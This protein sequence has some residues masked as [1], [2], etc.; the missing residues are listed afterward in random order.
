MIKK[1]YDIV[2]VGAGLSGAVLAE[3]FAKQQK[4]KVLLIEK[5]DHIGGNCFD[6]VDKNGI[7]INKYGAHLFHTN[8]EDVWEYVN[9]FCPWERWDHRVLGLLGN[10]LIN[11]PINI[12]TVNS[13]FQ[14][15]LKNGDDMDEWLSINQVNHNPIRDSKEMA[16]SRIGIDLY[17]KVIKHYSHKQWGKYPEELD[18]SV[19]ARIPVRNSFDDRYFTDKYQVLPERGYTFF[20]QNLL[21]SPN[22]DVLLHTDFFSLNRKIDYGY[23]FYT[24][25]IDDYFTTSGVERLEY[26]SINFFVEHYKNMNYY[27]ENSVINYL[28][29]EN[30][31]TRSVE[32]KH[33]LKQKSLHTTVVK[34][35]FTE[36][37][38]PYYPMFDNRNL[39]LYKRYNEF[40]KNEKKV[41]FVGRLANFKYFNMDQAIKNSLDCYTSFIKG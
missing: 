34:E 28:D 16:E 11:I 15:H 32:Y 21:S 39:L 27:Q 25:P 5:R 30:P 4:L 38:E 7:L 12:N 1:K 19:L 8:Y 36:K 14:L 26:R 18:P 35:I 17:E 13:V 23:T 22:I 20:V 6:Y 9:S 37:G 40:A 24:G 31:F 29:P 10:K 41:T 3:R 2:V 33:F